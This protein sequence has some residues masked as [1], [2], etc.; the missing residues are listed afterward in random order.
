MA[1]IKAAEIIDWNIEV[2]QVVSIYVDQAAL[3]ALGGHSVKSRL[4]SECKESLRGL[5]IRHDISL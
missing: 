3:K 2:G 1:I 4:V 5:D